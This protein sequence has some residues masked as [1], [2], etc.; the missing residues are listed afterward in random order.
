MDERRRTVKGKERMFKN[1]KLEI[2]KVELKNSNNK[3]D[4]NAKQINK[5]EHGTVKKNFTLFTKKKK[6]QTFQPKLN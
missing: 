5:H 4:N 2:N 6:K 1:E 3:T